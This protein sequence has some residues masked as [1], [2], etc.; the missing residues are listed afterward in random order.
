MVESVVF[1]L[2]TVDTTKVTTNSKYQDL[3]HLEGMVSRGMETGAAAG[4]DSLAA[5]VKIA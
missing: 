5:I 1:E 3:A 2:V 4:L